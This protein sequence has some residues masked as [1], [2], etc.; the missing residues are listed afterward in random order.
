MQLKYKINPIKY[1]TTK[2]IKKLPEIQKFLGRILI[3][4]MYFL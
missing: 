4:L 2:N 1:L 3:A